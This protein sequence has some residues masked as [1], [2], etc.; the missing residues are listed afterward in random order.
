MTD[1]AEQARLRR[2]F[3]AALEVARVSAKPALLELA[4]QYNA[5]V[6]SGSNAAQLRAIMQE[7]PVI[8]V[9][10]S[11]VDANDP[12][13]AKALRDLGLTLTS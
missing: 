9:G 1:T 3:E 2:K 8:Q 13:V 5:A 6:D 12:E 10:L 11:L 7:D 4:A